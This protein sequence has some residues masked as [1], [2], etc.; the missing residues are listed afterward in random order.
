MPATILVVDFKTKIPL[1]Y[2]PPQPISLS[3]TIYKQLKYINNHIF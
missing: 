1:F 3:D 2:I